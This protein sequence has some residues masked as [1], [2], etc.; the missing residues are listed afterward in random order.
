MDYV[1]GRRGLF[2][3]LAAALLVAMICY[4]SLAALHGEHGLFRLMTIEAEEVRLNA[5]LAEINAAQKQIANKNVSLSG[6]TDPEIIEE[7]AR[8]TLGLARTDE[9]LSR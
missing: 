8:K 5:E 7:Q 6:G 9:V 4:L 1:N 2:G 3:V